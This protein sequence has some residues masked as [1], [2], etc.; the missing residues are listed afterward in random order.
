MLSACKLNWQIYHLSLK[1]Y[2][3]LIINFSSADANVVLL[4]TPFLPHSQLSHARLQYL[5]W[6]SH[7]AS[8]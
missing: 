6:L 4:L 1:L 2:D 8:P 3:R 7:A 5:L